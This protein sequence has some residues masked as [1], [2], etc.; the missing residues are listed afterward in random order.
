M[1]Y[2]QALAI[3]DLSIKFDIDDFERFMLPALNRDLMDYQHKNFEHLLDTCARLNIPR[4]KIGQYLLT[5]LDDTDG[6][7][8]FADLVLIHQD[9]IFPIY[10]SNYHNQFHIDGATCF[11]HYYLG[12]FSPKT[13]EKV[14]EYV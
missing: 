13:R 2:K 1:D 3:R 10:A 6:P 5:F 4:V 9:L 14:I 11:G 12:T 7:F 8:Y